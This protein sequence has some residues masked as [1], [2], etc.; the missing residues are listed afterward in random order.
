MIIA[1][2][3][4]RIETYRYHCAAIAAADS[5]RYLDGVVCSIDKTV[6]RNHPELPMLREAVVARRAE[7]GERQPTDKRHDSGTFPPADWTMPAGWE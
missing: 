4:P 2:D 1:E 7:L 6:P 5:H 3:A